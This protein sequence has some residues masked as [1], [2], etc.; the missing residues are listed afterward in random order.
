[1]TPQEIKKARLDAG[2]TQMQAAELVAKQLR[3]WQRYEAGGRKIDVATW[4]LFKLKTGQ[5]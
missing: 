3:T 5:K 1:M 4:E 2:L